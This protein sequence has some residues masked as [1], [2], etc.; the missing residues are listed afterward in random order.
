MRTIRKAVFPVAGMGTRFLPATKA[1]AKEMLPVVDK[2][3]IQYAVEEAVAAGIDQVVF[4]TGRGKRSI[5]DHFDHQNGLETLLLEQGK[6]HLA[7]VYREVSDMADVT[8]VRQKQPL[9]LGHAVWC[10]RHVIGD[11]PF[12]VLLPDDLIDAEPGAIAQM[13]EAY[14]ATGGSS[15][16]AVEPVDPQAVKSY[17][18]VDTDVQDS[19]SYPVRGLVEKPDPAVAPSNLGVIGRYIL[20]PTVFE[21]LGRAERGAGGEIQLT[22]ALQA[23]ITEYGE[24]LHAFPFQGVR[25][26]CGSKAGYLKAQVELGLRHAE[27]GEELETFLRERLTRMDNKALPGMD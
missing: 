26:D 17:G 27:F 20:S 19:A 22:D 3:L 18:V 16:V 23:L 4:V 25:F 6:E 5:E 11:E 8:Y 15:Q 1:M 21:P 10:A 9:G 2:P 14:E 24:S 13:K 7:Q 12:A